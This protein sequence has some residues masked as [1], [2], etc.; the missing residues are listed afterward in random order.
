MPIT[1]LASLPNSRV[2]PRSATRDAITRS[3]SIVANTI[4]KII[5]VNP[6]RTYLFI[7]NTHATASLKYGYKNDVDEIKFSLRADRGIDLEALGEV[8]ALSTDDLTVEY[9]EGEG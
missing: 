6:D 3:V 4:T 1:N 9:D 7:Y 5:D 2:K 8:Y